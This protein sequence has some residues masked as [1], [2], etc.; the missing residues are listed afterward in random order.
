M[1]ELV[2]CP[3]AEAGI[4]LDRREDVRGPMIRVGGFGRKPNWYLAYE[5]RPYNPEEA[6]RGWIG[7]YQHKAFYAMT[8]REWGNS[9]ATIVDHLVESC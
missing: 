1:P 2:V 5:A 7:R 4:V 8:P 9:L 3:G 6:L